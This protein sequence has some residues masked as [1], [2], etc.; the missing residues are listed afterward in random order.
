M[1]VQIQ[2]NVGFP[3][4]L[5]PTVWIFD[6]RK[7]ELNEAFGVSDNE[8]SEN[9]QQQ[10]WDRNE[11]QQKLRPPVNQSVTRYNRKKVL[12]N[13]YVMPLHHFLKNSEPS[14]D[15]K[16]AILHT[17]D[18]DETISLDQLE[19]SYLLFALDGKP[20]TEDGPIHVILND[21]S[22]KDAPFKGVEKISIV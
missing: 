14:G 19:Q 1:I 20:L 6:D 7:I 18:G 4:T 22:N 3:I 17:T 11:Y 15:A 5:D 21:G 13:S 16:E 10:V 12:E 8:D 2:G 9:D